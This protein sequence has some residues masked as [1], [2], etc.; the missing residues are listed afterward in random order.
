MY[1]GYES[2]N[3]Q[4]HIEKTIVLKQWKIKLDLNLCKACS[5]NKCLLV[6][7]HKMFQQQ[8][9]RWTLCCNNFDTLD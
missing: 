6:K 5:S 4:Y 9:L 3:L 1:Y 8:K 2:L 7:T